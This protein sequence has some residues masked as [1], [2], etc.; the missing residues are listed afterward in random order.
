MMKM[1]KLI[2]GAFLLVSSA[3]VFGS[4]V[5]VDEPKVCFVCHD[6]IEALGKKKFVH[7][8]FKQGVCSACHN[9]HASRHAALT[10]Q[11]VTKLCLTCHADIKAQ[12]HKADPHQP[13]LDGDCITCHDPH[14]SDQK[15]QLKQKMVALC[16][17]CHTSIAQ[18]MTRASI[19]APVK[20]ENC[21]VC[22][23]PHGSDNGRLLTKAMP[24]ICFSCH[25]QDAPF[26]TAHKGYDLSKANCVTC[27][28]PHSS[29]TP[30][31]LMV[32]QHPPFRA[33]QCANC[34]A[35]GGKTAFALVSEP[36]V[37]CVR[38]HKQIQEFLAKPYH[39]NLTD[40]RSC[41]NC[42]NPHA[43]SG[44]SL[45]AAEQKDLC[46]RC[47]F[48]GDKYKGHSR[49]EW[50]THGGMDCTNCHT[51]HG[52]DNERFFKKPGVDLCLDC[53]KDAHK[54]S[55]PVGEKVIDPRTGGQL[56]CISCHKL[57]GSDFKPYLPLDPAR[58]LCLQ[59]HKR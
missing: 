31:L 29:T 39:H 54:G 17:Q 43:A 7:T 42:H 19:H 46:F 28:D 52:G 16:T 49:D 10:T 36:K 35:A 57:H 24:D 34:H 55:H 5:K 58:D 40:E 22:H 48:K 25:K 15:F 3:G 50:L 14:A 53:H 32:N 18:W 59:C 13:A 11:D 33:G 47:H 44:K 12:T 45:L 27:H 26:T 2:L 1:Y 30:N 6:N 21:V 51:P 23:T 38:C 4:V 41:L 56:T 9:P 8:A 37:L 20:A